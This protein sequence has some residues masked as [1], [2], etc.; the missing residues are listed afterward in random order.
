MTNEERGARS[1]KGPA[2]DARRAA[3]HSTFWRRAKSRTGTAIGA[4]GADMPGSGVAASV[5]YTVPDTVAEL[6]GSRASSDDL[7]ADDDQDLF[8]ATASLVRPYAWTGGRTRSRVP[9]EMETLVSTASRFGIGGGV[10]FEYQ[11]VA[12]LCRH[13]HSVAEVA[14]KLSVPLGVARVLLSDMAEQGL[15]KVH[16]SVADDDI[17]AHLVLM[18]RVLSGLRRL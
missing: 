15:I 18:E 1:R 3:T 2:H 5:P 6:I 10:G 8:E 16:D 17:A 4:D 11:S 7:F 13:P 12:S 14:A 9:L